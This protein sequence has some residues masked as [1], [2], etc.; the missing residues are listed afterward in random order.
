MPFFWNGRYLGIYTEKCIKPWFIS[1]KI[2]LQT[3]VAKPCEKTPQNN[4]T[5]ENQTRP[6]ARS[7][8]SPAPRQMMN[9]YRVLSLLFDY[10]NPHHMLYL[11]I[12][13]SIMHDTC[14]HSLLC[15]ICATS[16]CIRILVL[17]LLFPLCVWVNVLDIYEQ[18]T[19]KGAKL[20]QYE[21]V[22]DTKT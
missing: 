1:F 18:S 9:L 17:F 5:I 15:D 22:T 10:E 6:Y 7:L 3:E 21:G 2:I 4:T 12:I 11:A 14:F 13:L 20:R 8:L 16:S 19:K